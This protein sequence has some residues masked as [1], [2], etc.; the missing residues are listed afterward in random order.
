MLFLNNTALL[1]IISFD[2]ISN[3]KDNSEELLPSCLSY[4]AMNYLSSTLP[5]GL[6]GY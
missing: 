6:Q 1:D 2:C 4:T 5:R 3:Q